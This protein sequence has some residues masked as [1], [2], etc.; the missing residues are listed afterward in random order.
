[1]TRRFIGLLAAVL[2]VSSSGLAMAAQGEMG[3]GVP[4][5]LGLYSN[6]TGTST[7]VWSITDASTPFPAGCPQ[8]TLSPVTMGMDAYKIA[9]SAILLAK[10]TGKRIRFYAH[11]PRDAGCGVD[12]VEV[13]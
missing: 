7:I 8:I 4:G 1:M 5:Q 2:V 11:A 3:T 12:Y 13:Q 6:A 10:S 9:L